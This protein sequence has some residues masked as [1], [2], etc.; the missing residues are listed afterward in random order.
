[1]GL[2]LD[3]VTKA[4][5]GT[6]AVRDLNLTVPEGSVFGLLGANGAGKTTTVRLI[7]RLL[8]PD[9]GQIRWR[10]TPITHA[11]VRRFGYLPEERGLYPR[12]GVLDHIRYLASLRTQW[13][14]DLA[15]EVMAWLERLGI[16]HAVGRRVEQLSKGN[17][18]RVQ[19]VAAVAHRPELV[20]LD[21]PF[22]G[23]D[24]IGV[25]ALRDCIQL[26]R[27]R[28]TTVI[29][30][31]HLLRQVEQLCTHVALVHQG[32]VVLSGS[33]DEVRRQR[34]WTVVELVTGRT[35]ELD[36]RVAGVTSVRQAGDTLVLRVPS[37]EA[38]QAVLQAAL[39]EAPVYRFTIAG[40][41]LEEIYRETIGGVH[42]ACEQC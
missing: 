2:D 35:V 22:S 10:G 32:R 38:A 13:T 8:L 7:L 31:S 27:E 29:L 19:F 37:V 33:L 23:L 36:G 18:Q 17:Q 40:A 39:A 30:C 12:M 15:R 11:V 21:E 26:L 5:A 34:G 42:P 41:S 20:I 16:V 1:M 6:I 14:S 28:G 3:G 4:F 25:E 9:W 24:P